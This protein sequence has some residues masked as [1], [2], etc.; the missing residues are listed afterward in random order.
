M[1]TTNVLLGGRGCTEAVS[2]PAGDVD[3]VS[4]C[5]DGRR[6]VVG[7]WRLDG[8]RMLFITGATNTV[9]PSH[10]SW[11]KKK[12]KRRQRLSVFRHRNTYAV[13]KQGVS[14]SWCTSKFILW[15]ATAVTRSNPVSKRPF[16]KAWTNGGQPRGCLSTTHIRVQAMREPHRE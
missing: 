15:S 2:Y 16:L 7:S 13:D 10:L 3:E 4:T 14:S 6:F 12:K 11:K 1:H 9:L 5:R 8:L